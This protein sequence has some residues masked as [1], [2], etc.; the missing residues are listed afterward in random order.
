MRPWGEAGV[1]V[2]EVDVVVLGMG[3]GGE[4]AA[5]RLA[6]AGLWVVGVE[7]GLVGGECPYWGCVPSKMMIRA[8]RA[9]RGRRIGG[10]AGTATVTPTGPRWPPGSGKK[11]PTTGT[12]G[13]RSSGSSTRA[14][15]IKG[16]GRITARAGSGRRAVLRAGAG[17]SSTPGRGLG[18]AHPRPGRP[19]YWSNRELI[20]AEGVPVRW[21]CSAG[22]HRRRTVPGVARF[23]VRVTIVRGADGCSPPR[24]RSR[25][26][27]HGR[28]RP[29]GHRG[30]HRHRRPG[31]RGPDGT[32]SPWPVGRHR[33]SGAAPAGGHRP[34]ARPGRDGRSE[35][36]VDE[37]PGHPGGRRLRAAPACGPSATSPAGR[38]TH[39]SMYQADIAVA[40]IFGRR[41]PAEYQA[42]PRVTFTDPEVGSV[43]LTEAARAGASTCGPAATRSQVHPGLDPQGRQRGFIKLVADAERGPGRGQLGRAG[44]GRGAAMLTLAVYAGVATERLRQ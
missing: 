22:G 20:E 5:G 29:G 32:S 23:G 26:P 6:E 4:D 8:G 16:R 30:P 36:G 9:G 1:T 38:V 24:S 19:P 33:G 35:L 21:W 25:G 31:G 7:A 44:R 15:V 11:R 40:D 41:S 39:I 12:T 17:S 34:A 18:P 28:L 14:A 10:L 2:H 13:S 3:P 37:G 42:V 27:A 43:G